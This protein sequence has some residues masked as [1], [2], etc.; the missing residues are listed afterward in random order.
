MPSQPDPERP[1]I[2]PRDMMLTHDVRRLAGRPGGPIARS[3]L[4]RWRQ[5]RAFPEPVRVFKVGQGKRRQL[6]EVWDRR[7]V[8]A[9]LSEHPPT[10][11]EI[12][13]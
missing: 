4:I 6:I 5:D 1:W 9:W 11:K 8:R 3:T 10:T 13:P 2:L 12:Q 7:D